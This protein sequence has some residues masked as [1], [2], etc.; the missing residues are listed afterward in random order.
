MSAL[1]P[2]LIYQV[3][4]GLYQRHRS[5]RAAAG[6]TSASDCLAH[7]IGHHTGLCISDLEKVSLYMLEFRWGNGCEVEEER[8]RW[9]VGTKQTIGYDAFN[10]MTSRSTTHEGRTR[11]LTAGYTNNRITLVWFRLESEQRPRRGRERNGQSSIFTM[12]S[13]V[14][15]R[16]GRD[17]DQLGRDHTHHSS[18]LVTIQSK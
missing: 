5:V 13:L 16:C 10:N 11:S 9:D 18:V 15:I 12:L 7:R 1:L 8:N 3:R 14:D 2:K 6:S 17:D 4:Q